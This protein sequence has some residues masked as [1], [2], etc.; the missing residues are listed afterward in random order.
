MSYLCT[1]SIPRKQPLIPT[2]LPDYP[3]QKVATD[4]F[5][6]NGATYLLTVDYFSRYP[7]VQRLSTL[8]SQA[9]IEALKTCFSRYGIPEV[10]VSDN[11]PQYSSQEFASFVKDYDITHVTSSPRFST[12]QWIGRESCSDSQEAPEG[13]NRCRDGTASVPDYT[14]ALLFSFSC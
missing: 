9:V 12:E 3:W 4:L 7:E 13:Y 11:G 1:E 6:L 5:H 14:P 8:S 10:V 2:P